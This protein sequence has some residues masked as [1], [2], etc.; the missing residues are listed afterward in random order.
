MNNIAKI[1]EQELAPLFGA[2]VRPAETFSGEKL[3]L[4]K[5]HGQSFD[6]YTI[7]KGDILKF[8]AFDDML[9]KSQ[10]V[11]RPRANE[12]LEDVPKVDL[13]ACQLTRNGKTR[14]SW[15]NVNSLGRKDADQVPVM[16]EWSE[17]E[18][19]FAKLQK[20]AEMGAITSGE[21]KK[22]KSVVFDNET[23][24]PKKVKELGMDGVYR[25][26]DRNELR[27]QTV[28]TVVQYT[29]A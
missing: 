3:K 28:I 20:L 1:S 21:E 19:V 15:F 27:D 17:H 11:R 14:N 18:N 4:L 22:I 8:P 10:C 29:G 16:P 13:V 2:N 9:V 5:N 26:T 24:R 12:K 25:E 7:Q 23:G 6:A